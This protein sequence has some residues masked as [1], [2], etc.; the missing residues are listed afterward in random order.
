MIEDL[1]FWISWKSLNWNI[2]QE[3]FPALFVM[4]GGDLKK[5]EGLRGPGKESK[6]V[7]AGSECSLTIMRSR[8]ADCILRA[9][10]FVREKDS[11]RKFYFS[12]P[13]LPGNVSR[14]FGIILSLIIVW[15]V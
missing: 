1:V 12:L 7:L 8:Q 10:Q 9:F 6:E 13:V 5:W 4:L 2:G 11:L 15:L 3:M 14:L